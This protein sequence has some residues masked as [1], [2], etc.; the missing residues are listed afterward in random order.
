MG[1]RDEDDEEAVQALKNV[2]YALVNKNFPDATIQQAGRFSKEF[3]DI[4]ALVPK[5]HYTEVATFSGTGTIK[6]V[7]NVIS[8]ALTTIKFKKS[9]G[10]SYFGD[11]GLC[12]ITKASDGFSY[13][14]GIVSDTGVDRDNERF[15]PS[16]L[17]QMKSAIDNGMML[18]ANH[19]HNIENTLGVFTKSE[20]LNNGNTLWAEARLEDASKNANV[21]SLLNKLET[22]MTLGFSIG[23]DLLGEK[24]KE[25]DSKLGQQVGTINSLKLYEVSAV[26]LP[27]NPRALITGVR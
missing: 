19:D 20:L 26:A 17:L 27:S 22:G 23:G 24:K 21:A 14:S 7:Q 25:Y 11:V 13:I 4:L 15:S 2:V 18:F 16:A 5:Q 8:D 6:D 1:Y 12:S 10:I 3:E 9:Y